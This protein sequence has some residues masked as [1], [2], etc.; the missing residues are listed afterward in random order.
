MGNC[1]LFVPEL[2]RRLV[3]IP[4]TV[5][6]GGFLVS[7]GVTRRADFLLEDMAFE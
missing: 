3:V 5:S 6:F 4:R 7:I 2:D 1:L